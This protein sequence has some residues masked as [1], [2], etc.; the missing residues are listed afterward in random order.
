[1]GESR[2]LMVRGL[3]NRG[4]LSILDD[5]CFMTRKKESCTYI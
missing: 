5:K 4:T 2:L 3:F 1:M